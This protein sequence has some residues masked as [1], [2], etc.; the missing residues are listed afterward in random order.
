MRYRLLDEDA[1]PG[2]VCRECGAPITEEQSALRH[3]HTYVHYDCGTEYVKSLEA[4]RADD[5]YDRWRDA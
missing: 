5:A 1:P 4:C 3:G 2:E